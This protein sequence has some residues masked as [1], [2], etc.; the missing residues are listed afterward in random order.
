MDVPV[1]YPEN[2]EEAPTAWEAG[3]D[4][5]A[6]TGEPGTEDGAEPREALPEIADIEEQLVVSEWPD[7]N[8]PIVVAS[9]DRGEP[10]DDDKD[11]SAN[12]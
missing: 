11:A 4:E 2:E 3:S 9:L 7:P 1:L 12:G 10:D 5:A 8:K 6:M